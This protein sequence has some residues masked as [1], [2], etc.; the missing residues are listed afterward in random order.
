M[1]VGDRLS[2]TYYKENKRAFH[3]FGNSLMKRVV[4]SIFG[5]DIKDIMTGYRALSYRFVKTFAVTSR[6]F[7]IETEMTVH[8][9]HKNMF[10]SNVVV[11]YRDRH[12]SES[13]LNTS[14]D[15]F[16]VIRTTMRLFRCYRPLKFF[17]ILATVAEV[18]F[19]APSDCL[20]SRIAS[21]SLSGQRKYRSLLYSS[22]IFSIEKCFRR[23]RIC[24]K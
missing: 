2:S 12:G 14:R 6:G 21:Q 17:S 10:V 19:Q 7:E 4:N 13:K 5:S 15:G 11:D 1:A 24:S 20:E 8:A 3:N 23:M 16:R 9:I 18:N 22:G